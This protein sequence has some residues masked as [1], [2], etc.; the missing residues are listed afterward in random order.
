MNV[1]ND[2]EVV[3]E[4]VEWSLVYR[5]YNLFSDDFLDILKLIHVLDH[6]HDVH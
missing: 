1:H 5:S 4:T 2:I 6:K 3:G